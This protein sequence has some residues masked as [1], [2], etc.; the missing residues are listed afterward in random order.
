[1]QRRQIMKILSIIIKE[2]NCRRKSVKRSITFKTELPRHLII[3]TRNG[4]R[5]PQISRE[6]LEF[7]RR[8]VNS[9]TRKRHVGLR[10]G[11]RRDLKTPRLKLPRQVGVAICSVAQTATEKRGSEPEEKS[12]GRNETWLPPPRLLK[13]SLEDGEEGESRLCALRSRGYPASESDFRVIERRNNGHARTEEFNFQ[14][15]CAFDFPSLFSPLSFAKQTWGGKRDA[16]CVKIL[17][18]ICLNVRDKH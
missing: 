13:R 4:R 16:T 18:T 9:V 12:D 10:E 8:L 2:S 1:M 5:I 6:R 15:G 14:N 17:F 3:S 11:T 7:S